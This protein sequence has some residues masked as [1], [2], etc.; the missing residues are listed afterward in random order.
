MTESPN[1]LI[2]ISCLKDWLNVAFSAQMELFVRNKASILD[3]IPDW[4]TRVA[5][6]PLMVDYLNGKPVLKALIE[7]VD[8]D[9]VKLNSFL[10]QQDQMYLEQVIQGND[11]HVGDFVDY[12]WSGEA[13]RASGASMI[14]L[15]SYLV[16]RVHEG[17]IFDFDAQKISVMQ[18]PKY[19][20]EMRITQ[21]RAGM[22][23]ARSAWLGTVGSLLGVLYTA[24]P[25]AVSGC[26]PKETRA[27][28]PNW[29][30]MYY[31]FED[32]PNSVL[33]VYRCLTDAIADERISV[34]ADDY[35]SICTIMHLVRITTSAVALALGN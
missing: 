17:K 32:S 35:E 16:Q 23:A 9:I 8:F 4:G 33:N 34:R 5:R 3:N 2:L 12:V 19:A 7:S 29:S 21:Y 13:V 18:S 1:S 14:S 20:M 28:I 25:D 10:G 31:N 26:F 11:V 22:G 24:S 27:D 15:W 30:A 6:L